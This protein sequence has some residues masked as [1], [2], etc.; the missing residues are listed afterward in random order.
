M[1][2]DLPYPHRRFISVVLGSGVSASI[3]FAG[4][5]FF[6]EREGGLT[7]PFFNLISFLSRWALL[8]PIYIYRYSLSSIMG[9]HC[10]H[11]PSCSAYAIE[12]IRLNGALKGFW[13]GLSRIWRCGPGG[14]HGFDPVPDL[15]R[16]HHPFY[17]SWRYGVWS[18]PVDD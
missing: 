9:R 4:T 6:V 11:E 1:R 5:R 8:L 15:R 17:L 10:R 2:Q 18:R 14:S 7:R 12:A 16:V 13:L 3:Q